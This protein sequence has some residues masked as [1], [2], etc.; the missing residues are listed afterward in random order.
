VLPQ[1]WHISP[2]PQR[3]MQWKARLVKRPR[4]V[5]LPSAAMALATSAFATAAPATH[6]PQ[7]ELQRHLDCA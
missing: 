6:F 1:R 2:N 5:R 4:A 7:L 3:D